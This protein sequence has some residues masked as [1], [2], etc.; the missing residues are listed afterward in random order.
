M[1]ITYNLTGAQRKSL[2]GA[3]SQE[4]NAKTKFLGAP[5]FGYEV[6]GYHIDKVGTITGEDNLDLEDA[7]QRR[8]FNAIEREYDKADTYESGLGGMTSEDEL[9]AEREMRRMELE[10]ENVP[11]YSNRGQYGGDLDDD[12][13]TIEMPLDG[14]TPEKLDNLAKMVNAKALLLKAALGTDELPIIQ[15]ADT[16]KFPW[17]KG[18]IDAEHTEAYAALVSL[19]C[20]AAIEKKRVTAKGKDEVDN[21]KYAMRCFLLSLGF[22]G[23]AYVTNYIM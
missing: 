8:G 18:P 2:V 9:W 23:D 20:K 4:L 10:N 11:D 21:P 7:L 17:F 16:L 12:R 3:I 15:T 22:I 14:F 19:L 5:T 13:L 6:G 1:R